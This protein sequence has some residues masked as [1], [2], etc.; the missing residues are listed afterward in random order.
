MAKQQSYSN[1][2]APSITD[3]Q[4]MTPR[5]PSPK[6]SVP[7]LTC[8]EPCNVSVYSEPVYSDGLL[9]PQPYYHPPV[10]PGP[11]PGC[12]VSVSPCP[13]CSAMLSMAPV[14]GPH[15]SLGRPRTLPGLAPHGAQGG[16]LRDTG[17]YLVHM[18]PDP[19][20]VDRVS[21][22]HHHPASGFACILFGVICVFICFYFVL[23]VDLEPHPHAQKFHSWDRTA[24][25]GPSSNNISLR[26][27]NFHPGE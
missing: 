8:C 10:Y 25:S 15:H 21:G 26:R 20:S 22:L 17:P 4:Q 5:S 3:Q 27:K 19:D 24:R 9:Y 14:T 1:K 12:L 6:P 2:L 16:P 23:V 13:G 7:P 18:H 11:C